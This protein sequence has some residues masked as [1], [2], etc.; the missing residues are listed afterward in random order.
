MGQRNGTTK[1]IPADDRTR[2]N[3]SSEWCWWTDYIK[4]LLYEIPTR[5]TT[6]SGSNHFVQ[7]HSCSTG[8]SLRHTNDSALEQHI[9]WGPKK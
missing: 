8:N 4:I 1:C 7:R 9:I 3:E 5:S 6:V 2:M